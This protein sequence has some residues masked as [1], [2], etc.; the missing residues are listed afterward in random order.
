MRQSYRENLS[1]N[2]CSLHAKLAPNAL[3]YNEYG[4]TEC[5]IGTTIAR[6]YSP[7][8]QTIHRITVGKPLPNTQ[9]YILDSNLNVLPQGSKGEIC[10]SG[11]G[12]AK[13]Y[14]GRKKLTAQKF[15]YLTTPEGER[16]RIYRT[17]DMGR[18][19][20]NHELEFLGRFEQEVQV[21]GKSIN[22]GEIEHQ[23]SHHPDIQ[24]SAVVIEQNYQG[25]N[26][27]IVYF[28]S[29]KKN[30]QLSLLRYLKT[31]FGKWLP[32]SVIPITQFPLSSNG[33]IDRHA[34]IGCHA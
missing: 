18:M 16:V 26:Q 32:L 27:L 9:V 34:L 22:L 23:I 8:H 20:P 15:S 17:G 31:N 5:A 3:L 12:L 7:Q 19:L 1:K 6:I 10:I 21:L 28:T 24:E 2:L 25:E 29:L 4:P 14:F 11:I 13:E 30:A 33:K